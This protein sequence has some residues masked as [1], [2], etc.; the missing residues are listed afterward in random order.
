[1]TAYLDL[2]Y[3]LG[4]VDLCIHLTMTLK[5]ERVSLL[6]LW[7]EHAASLIWRTLGSSW[8]A[9]SVEAGVW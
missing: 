9:H 1:M 5:E 8:V 7:F 2:G 3:F 4:N 6:R